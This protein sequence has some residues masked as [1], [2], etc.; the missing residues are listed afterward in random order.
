MKM[1]RNVALSRKER[2]RMVNENRVG[3]WIQTYSGEPFW[4]F[5]PRVDEIR[6]EDIAHALSN[7][8]RF[9][10]HTRQFYSVAQHSV[11]VS[12]E[13]RR[14]LA[15]QALMHD[16]SEAYLVDLPKPLKNHGVLGWEY[17][18]CEERL[19]KVIAERFNLGWPLDPEVKRA[20]LALLAAERWELMG[21]CSRPWYSEECVSPSLVLVAAY[22]PEEAKAAFLRRAR[23]LGVE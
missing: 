5:D 20:D 16:A 3:D 11:L 8:C 9:S 18:R 23:E 6:L 14:D 21:P 15:R 22:G 2:C 12:L 7:Q 19:M 13:V 4:P 17:R 10:G 1:I